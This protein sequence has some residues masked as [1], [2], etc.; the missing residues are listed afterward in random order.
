MAAPLAPG[1]DRL[2]T[3]SAFSVLARAR[4][5]EG[6]GRDIVHL[7]IGEPDFPTPAHISEAAFT[8]V[9]AGATHYCPSAGL[10]ELREAAAVALSATR[11]IDVPQE[12]VLVGNGA[13]P[14]LFFTILATCGAG[15][16]VVY[17]DPGFPIY[18]SAIRW[19][20]ATPVP[21][22]LHEAAD[23]S[24]DV[25]ELEAKLSERTALVILNSPQNPTGGV[26]PAGDLEAAAER[27]AATPAWVLS[28]E[29]YA[30]MTY[31]GPAASIA[32]V[33]GMLDRTVLLD[34]FSKTYA[35]T[36]WRCGYACVPE[37]L[38]EPLS[39]FIVNS[40]S[41]VPPFVQHAGVAALEGP[42]DEVAAMLA[43]FRVRRDTVVDGLNALPG[44]TCRTPPGAFY[45]FPNVSGV[46]LGADDLAVRLLEE[47]GVAVLAG[48]AERRAGQ[49]HLRISYAASREQLAE[50]LR[51]M[52]D[53]LYR[54]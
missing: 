30:R 54:V 17:P 51:R 1:V 4:E 37:A 43:E 44:V 25:D 47:A 9:R 27:I 14:L 24:F 39:R 31:D 20:G 48:P 23:F 50:A 45:A 3:E 5:L 19:A 18:E 52:E 6:T 28:D 15:D 11:G 38:L 53:F 35:M 42:Q 46:P 29:V 8:A 21:L 49:D 33:P 16:E 2:G 7:E 32:S 36:G 34:G 10:P 41:C 13:K 40:T 26:V 12:R 22:P